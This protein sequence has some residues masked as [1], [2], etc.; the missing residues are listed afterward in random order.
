[1][2]GKGCAMHDLLITHPLLQGCNPT[3]KGMYMVLAIAARGQVRRVVI[4]VRSDEEKIAI[5]CDDREITPPPCLPNTIITLRRMSDI[6]A[7]TP[8]SAFQS[9][10]TE[11][12]EEKVFDLTITYLPDCDTEGELRSI[13]E[14]LK[15]E[16][17]SSEGL[18]YT[19]IRNEKRHVLMAYALMVLLV[20][21]AVAS[22]FLM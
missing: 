14:Q 13:M 21:I 16:Q 19:Q 11:T 22:Y 8:N 20:A 2:K 5:Q 3:L 4:T 17:E 18:E 7:N 1:M 9:V 6:I 10:Y 12:A 15:T